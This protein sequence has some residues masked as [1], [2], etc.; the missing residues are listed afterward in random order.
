MRKVFK[1]VLLGFII[2]TTYSLASCQVGPK[3]IAVPKYLAEV[4]IPSLFEL[5]PELHN[6]AEKWGADAQLTTVSFEIMPLDSGKDVSMFFI[7]SNR[8]YE[9]LIIQ[10][11]VDGRIN[12]IFVEHR[13]PVN[14]EIIGTI[15][16]S[17]QILDSVDA[18]DTF[19]GYPE[20]L[21]YGVETFEC[22]SLIL[23]PSIIEGQVAVWRL[24]VGECDA[25]ER[26]FFEIDACTGEHLE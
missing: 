23:A 26:E 8:A 3:T 18:W 6:E 13:L 9:S 25:S 20:V 19:L 22:A 10:Y 2:V 15:E 21:S 5:Y 14:E 16:L 17:E 12:T 1:K 11:W 4:E 24:S 7:S